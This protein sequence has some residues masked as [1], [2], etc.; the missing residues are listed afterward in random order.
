LYRSFYL[1]RLSETCIHT[2]R[3]TIR[4]RCCVYSK[5]VIYA[6]SILGLEYYVIRVANSNSVFPD[7]EGSI[8]RH[9]KRI[10]QDTAIL[11]PQPTLNQLPLSFINSDDKLRVQLLTQLE[12][13]RW[14]YCAEC[15]LLSLESCLRQIRSRSCLWTDVVG[16]TMGS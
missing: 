11:L 13:S 3:Y 6:K 14:A 4:Y 9:C 16:A 1:S 10:F 5:L 7:M 8:G 15:F 2:D 12:N